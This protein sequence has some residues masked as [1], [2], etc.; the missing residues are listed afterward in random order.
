[1]FLPIQEFENIKN[2]KFNNNS[3]SLKIYNE[4][5]LLPFNNVNKNTIKYIVNSINEIISNI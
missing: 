3:K 1:M 5:I 2:I 4:Y